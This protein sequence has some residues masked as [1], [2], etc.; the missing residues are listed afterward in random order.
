MDIVTIIFGI[1]F[2]IAAIYQ[3]WRFYFRKCIKCGGKL[4]FD[5]QKDSMGMNISK[6]ITF[7]VWDGAREMTYVWKCEKCGMEITETNWE[8]D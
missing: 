2:I 3:I 4:K 7:S 1:G 5:S 8:T 6:K